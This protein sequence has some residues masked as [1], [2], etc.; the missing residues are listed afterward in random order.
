MPKSK[1]DLLR[2]LDVWERTQGGMAFSSSGLSAASSVMRKDFDGSAWST[3]HGNDYKELIASARMRKGS[4][5]NLVIPQPSPTNRETS[6]GPVSPNMNDR[7]NQSSLPDEKV[8]GES[9][10]NSVGSPTPRDNNPEGQAGIENGSQRIVIE[11][12]AA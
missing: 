5:G 4:E 2:E 10:S 8:S 1:R 12:A 7:E 11:D 6:Q 3:D 9:E